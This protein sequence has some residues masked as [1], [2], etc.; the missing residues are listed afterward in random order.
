M[1]ASVWI[2][3]DTLGYPSGAGHLWQ[4][5]NWAL[6]LRSVGCQV[7]WL[8]PCGRD[9]DPSA[10]ELLRGRLG[11]YGLERICLV[12]EAGSD[13]AVAYGG[14]P[15][16]APA[17]APVPVEA[18]ADADL[19]L[20]LAYDL[21][22]TLVERFRC[23]ALLDTDPGMAQTWFAHGDIE[24]GRYDHYLTIGEGVAN[25][26]GPVPDCGVRW[27]YA[28]PC[29]ALDSWTVAPPPAGGGGAYTTITH[30][31][32][33]SSFVMPDGEVIDNTKRSSF[34]PYLPV[35][36][37]AE[38]TIEVAVAPDDLEDDAPLLDQHGWSAT[39]PAEVAATPSDYRGFIERS[40]GEFSCAKPAYVALDTGW[41]SDRTVCYLAA[42]RP[43]IVQ[44]TGPCRLLDEAEGEGVFR[45][46]DA[47]QA[48]AA[49]RA[50]ERDHARQSAGARALAE[51][52]FDAARSAAR[53][54]EL[55]LD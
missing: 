14:V 3:A 12:D 52:S 7:T 29:A 48:V 10:V 45:F 39:D 54:L 20:N 40:R 44:H 53:L 36:R 27:V 46:R 8:E 18:A 31:W 21:P 34:L 28:P 38:V 26:R 42:G 15:A 16:P 30:W 43:V 50:V 24:L 9:V 23:T 55:C 5:L 1:S 35:A 41:I 13:Q 49:L 22:R 32:G 17:P 51:Q 19:L 6:G 47:G 2:A 4:F 37:A 11:S 25:G 33:D